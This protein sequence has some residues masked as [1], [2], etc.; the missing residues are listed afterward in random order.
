MNIDDLDIELFK[1]IWILEDKVTIS[2]IV[3][4]M[5]EIKNRK[6]Y[7]RKYALIKKRLEKLAKYGILN[8]YRYN[9]S[10]VYT[11]NKN[12]CLIGFF[13]NGKIVWIK[14]NDV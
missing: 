6:E 9:D 2:T 10:I 12:S 1:Y 11:L 5:F 8:K 3:K 13:I 14:L 4:D 7:Q